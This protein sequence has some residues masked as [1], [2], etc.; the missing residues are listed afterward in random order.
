MNRIQLLL[1][2]LALTAI[3]GC[4]SAPSYPPPKADSGQILVQLN[5]KAKEGV[6]GP[7]RETVEQEYSRTRESV[8]QGKAFERVDYEELEEVI[9]VVSSGLPILE[10]TPITDK[11]TVTL[12]V[13]G[14]GFD[15]SQV[16]SGPL[17]VF[18][19]VLSGIRIRNELD[20][21]LLIYGFSKDGDSFEVEVPANGEAQANVIQAGIYEVYCEQDESMSCVWHAV[22]RGK[23]WSGPSDE[24]AFFDRLPAGTYEVLVYPPRLPVWSRTITVTAGKRETVTADLT[25]NDLPKV[26]E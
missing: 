24:Q 18:R 11:A 25:V 26:G 16:V 21:P 20:H 15:R 10:D 13:N 2:G 9:V 7:K 3:S 4:A 22:T 6:G 5:G 14:D 8:E 1:V 23:V 17:S 12:T 19:K